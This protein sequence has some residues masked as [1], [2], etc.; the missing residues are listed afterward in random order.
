MPCILFLGF[1]QANSDAPAWHGNDHFT[2]ARHAAYLRVSMRKLPWE[3]F[4]IDLLQANTA[5]GVFSMALK[6]PVPIQLRVDGLTAAH[7]QVKLYDR[8]LL[9]GE[10]NQLLIDLAEAPEPLSHL[11]FYVN[12]GEQFTGEILVKEGKV[13]PY[14]EE[15]EVFSVYPNPTAEYLNVEL[16]D[17]G[18]NRLQVFD[19][20]GKLVQTI[21]PP[22]C[23][24]TL[25]L[26]GFRPGTYIVNATGPNLSLTKKF[27]VR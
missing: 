15:S 1:N 12:P 27:V 16:P 21:K 26:A 20:T 4:S 19:S 9:P 6:T 17:A 22:R 24:F 8:L 11:V 25:D 10:F 3:S 5:K 18:I 2:F 7:K 23:H 13:I 14:L